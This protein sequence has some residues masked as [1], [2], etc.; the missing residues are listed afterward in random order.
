MAATNTIHDRRHYGGR[1]K[2]TVV[3]GGR[4]ITSDKQVDSKWIGACKK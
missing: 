4:K 2:S 3:F 1:M